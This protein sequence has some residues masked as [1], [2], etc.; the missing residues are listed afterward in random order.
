MNPDRE[1]LRGDVLITDGRIAGVGDGLTVPPGTRLLDAAG[2]HVLPGLIQ[3]HV[4]LGQALFRGLAEDRELLSW[5]KDRVWPLEAAHD[6]DSAYW[7]G[8]LGASDALLSGTTTVQEIGL[9]REMDAIFRAILDSGLRAVAGKCLMD[10]GEDVPS[11]LLEDTRASLAEAESL[12]ATWHGAA[13]GRLRAAVCPRFVLSCSRELWEGTS[14]L[15]ARLHL[16]VNTHLLES[17]AEEAAVKDALGTGQMEFLDGTG[18]LDRDFRI[19]HGVWLQDS[20]VRTLGGRPLKVAHC[21]SANLKLGS[22]VAD[23]VFLRT[24]PGFSVGIGTDGAPCNND[25][26][27]LEEIR[28]GALLQQWKQG[29]GR[30]TARDALELAT[31]E[32]ARSLGWEDEIGSLEPGKAGDLVVLNLDRVASFGPEQVS[33]YDRIVY[34]AG[35]DQVQWVV[36]DGEV[37]VEAG[38]LTQARRGGRARHPARVHRPA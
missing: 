25:M 29:P 22:G 13:G 17:Q 27:I 1:V 10:W 28:L 26:D 32:G 5:L 36:V 14:D 19:A 18:V 35:R 3:A 4:H 30:F 11:R 20:H 34:G 21:P 16:P 12:A 33:V 38:R 6:A 2:L 9:V 24:Q 23:L 37:L 7:S 8:M 31:I 15:A